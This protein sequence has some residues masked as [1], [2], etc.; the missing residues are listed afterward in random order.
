MIP[1]KKSDLR[2]CFNFPVHAAY[3]KYASGYWKVTME[4]PLR[5]KGIDPERDYTPKEI[6]TL[7][8]TLERLPA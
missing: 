8:E 2:R 4:R 3:A 1:L 5:L 6:K 7:W